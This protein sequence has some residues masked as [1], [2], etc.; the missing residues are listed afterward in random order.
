VTGEDDAGLL[1]DCAPAFVE[2]IREGQ[3]LLV[4]ALDAEGRVLRANRALTR[5]LDRE[6]TGALV[7]TLVVPGC[8]AALGAA[9]GPSGSAGFVL[10]HLETERG[11]VSVRVLVA[12]H[13]GGH[14]LVGELPLDEQQALLEQLHALNADLAM[15]TRENARRAQELERAHAELRDAHWHIAKIAEV[16]PMCVGCRKVK[17]GPDVWESVS[18]YL[19][20]ST[21]FLSHG[22]CASCAARVAEQLGRE[23]P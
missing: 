4:L 12:A 15:L 8:R 18:S 11:P 2:L 3:S 20:R 6:V 16:L 9:R 10:L 13:R 5:L 1:A 7:D 23:E 14:V 17:T 19:A 22:Y 21:D